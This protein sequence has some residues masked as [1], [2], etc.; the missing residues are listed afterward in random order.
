M[1]LRFFAVAFCC[2]TS[3]LSSADVL[4][5]AILQPTTIHVSPDA[6]SARL[7]ELLRGREV[8][9]LDTSG[10]WSHVE[11]NVTDERTVT[12]WISDRCMVSANTPNGDRVLLGEAVESEDQASHRNGRNGADQDALRLYSEIAELFPNS[13]LAGEAMY[14]AADIRW[15][16]EKADVMTLPSAK[17]QDP[18]LRPQINEDYM[19]RVI[20]K[21]PGTKWADLAAF[22][23][24]DNKTCGDW[25]AQSKCPAKEAEIYEN[26]AKDHP[27]SPA[28]AEALYAAAWRWSALIE[29]YKSESQEK[30]SDQAKAKAIEVAQN[31][32]AQFPLSDWGARAQRLLFSIQRGIPTYGNGQQQ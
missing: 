14:R 2:L 5:G 13:Q 18:N 23:L 31:V 8:V 15:Q 28:L 1:T 32:V 21:F 6:S 24:I 16:I 7:G 27:Q 26:Y 20:K 12:G 4:R 25:Q 11:A 3:T 30:K 9:V 17:E 19:K 29:I 22:H 10:D